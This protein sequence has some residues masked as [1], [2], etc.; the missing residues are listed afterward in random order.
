MSLPAKVFGMLRHANLIKPKA[1]LIAHRGGLPPTLAGLT[2]HA[3]GDLPTIS[4]TVMLHPRTIRLNVGACAASTFTQSLR[5]R[6]RSA[7]S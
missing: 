3:E 2:Q 1:Q 5:W 7:V 4:R 6:N